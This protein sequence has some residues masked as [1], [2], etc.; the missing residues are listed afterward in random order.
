[1]IAPPEQLQLIEPD[2]IKKNNLD[3]ALP[4]ITNNYK[5]YFITREKIVGL[6]NLIRIYNKEISNGK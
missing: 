6:Q 5:T 3:L 1:M 4:I 2:I